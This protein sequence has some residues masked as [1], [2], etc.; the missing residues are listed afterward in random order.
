MRG[1]QGVG[2]MRWFEII[3]KGDCA[4]CGLALAQ[5]VQLAAALGDQL[6]FVLG[7]GGDCVFGHLTILR[8]RRQW[9]FHTI[10]LSKP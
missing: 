5:G 4:A 1:V 3:G 2:V 9:L 7:C 10:A 6:V 8:V